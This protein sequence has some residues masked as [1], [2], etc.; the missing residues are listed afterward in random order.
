MEKNMDFT[1]QESSENRQKA[2]GMALLSIE[3]QFGKGAIMKLG[4]GRKLSMDLGAISTGSLSLDLRPES[5]AFPEGGSSRSSDL[6]L[7][8]KRR[9][10]CIP[11]P[12]RRKRAVLP[13]SSMRNTLWI[14]L[15]PKSWALIRTN[16]SFPSRTTESRRWKSPRSWSA[17]AVSMSLLSIRWP[18]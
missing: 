4:D 18:H 14:L 9:L 11:R 17:A 13:L 12:R 7:P 2:V 16:C 10:H 5:E 3:K 15:M 6:S 1:R 8:V